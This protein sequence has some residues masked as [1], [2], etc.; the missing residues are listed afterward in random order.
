[1]DK[2]VE[3]VERV[4][5]QQALKEYSMLLAKIEHLEEQDWTPEEIVDW[6][7]LS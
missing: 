3:I 1:M 6:L 4:K 7:E 2:N 5:K